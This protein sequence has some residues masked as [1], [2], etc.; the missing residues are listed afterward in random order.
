VQSKENVSSISSFRLTDELVPK[1]YLTAYRLRIEAIVKACSM[2]LT[3]RLTEQN[4]LS[5]L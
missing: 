5:M 1:I 4:C 3:E 2:Y